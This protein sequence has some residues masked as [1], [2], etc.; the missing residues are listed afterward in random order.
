MLTFDR[1]TAIIVAIAVCVAATIYMYL[2]LKNT[3]EEMEGVKGVNGKITSFLSNIRPVAPPQS[4][5]EQ[6]QENKVVKQ[7]QVEVE[8][9][10]NSES[11]E[12]S[13]E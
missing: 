6:E 13:S 12:E 4:Y 7:T 5:Q 10:E 2:E 1:D 3:K 9:D 8:N 11:E